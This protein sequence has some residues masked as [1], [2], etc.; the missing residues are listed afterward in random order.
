MVDT[1]VG[2]NRSVGLSYILQHLDSPD[3][4][5]RVLFVDYS[6]AFNTIIPSKLFEKIQNVGVQ[7]S[8]CLWI[9]DFLLNKSQVVKIRGDLS[10]SLT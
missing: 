8:M 1:N 6:F 4:Y 7:Q 10:S 5:A 3:T 2:G 9:L